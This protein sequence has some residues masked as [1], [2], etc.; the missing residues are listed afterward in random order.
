MF[1]KSD[2]GSTYREGIC[3]DFKKLHQFLRDEEML[4]VSA[5]KQTIQDDLATADMAFLQVRYFLIGSKLYYLL[6]KNHS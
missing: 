3:E 5:L 2:P 1:P 6:R 4:R